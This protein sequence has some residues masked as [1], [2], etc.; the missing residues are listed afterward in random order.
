[1]KNFCCT[2]FVSWNI[3]VVVVVVVVVYNFITFYKFRSW[4]DLP[5]THM[6]HFIILFNTLH[7]ED[8]HRRRPK[9]VGVVNKQRI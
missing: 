6:Q 3:F 4:T 9:H 5:F 7:P 8:S 2:Q 1:M